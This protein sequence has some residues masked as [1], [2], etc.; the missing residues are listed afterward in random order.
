MSLVI[1][2]MATSHRKAVQKL[3]MFIKS[4]IVVTRNNMWQMSD[5]SSGSQI[6]AATNIGG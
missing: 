3:R 6:I 2:D 1:E 4:L 5:N